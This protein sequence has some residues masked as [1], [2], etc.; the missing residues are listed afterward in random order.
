MKNIETMY[1]GH[2]EDVRIRYKFGGK[3]IRTFAILSGAKPQTLL[4]S[5]KSVEPWSRRGEHQTGEGGYMNWS[6]WS[7]QIT[8]AESDEESD[9]RVVCQRP[10]LVL[11]NM[12]C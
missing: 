1:G 4:V 6:A 3:L 7:E 12:T 10:V 8:Q 11:T 2:H 9:S 5:A